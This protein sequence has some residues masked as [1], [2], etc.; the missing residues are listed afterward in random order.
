MASLWVR[1]HEYYMENGYA[2]VGI[3]SKDV[4]V[5][6]LKKFNSERYDVLNWNLPG[7]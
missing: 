5:N 6:T 2:Y 4:S 1:G 3:T 7:T